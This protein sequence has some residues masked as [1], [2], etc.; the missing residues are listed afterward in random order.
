MP[1]NIDAVIES[2]N[3]SS[4]TDTRP[5]AYQEI[6]RWSEQQL[7][8]WQSDALRRIVKNHD[9]TDQDVQEILVMLKVENGLTV[10]G[11]VA[12]KRLSESDIPAYS[13]ASSKIVLEAM[14]ELKNVNAIVPGQTLKFNPSGLTIVYGHNAS[15]K[16]GYA[17]VLKKACRARGEKDEVLPDVFSVSSPGPAEAV[18]DVNDGSKSVPIK[19]QEGV[20]SPDSLAG[21]NVFDSKC[22]RVYVD[23]SNEVVYVP[24]GLDAFDK[25]AKL[26]EKLKAILQAESTAISVDPNQ[27]NDLHGSTSVGQLLATLSYQTNLEIVERLAKLQPDEE[28][29]LA[30]V[31][32]KLAELKVNDPK[33]KAETLRIKKRRI[34]RFLIQ[35]ERIGSTVSTDVIT[36][37]KTAQGELYTAKE[38]SK[39]ASQKSF[40]S[41]PLNGVTTD[42]WKIMY[43]AA[44]A[45]S[46]QHAYPGESFPVTKDGARCVL[47][48]QE[49]TPEAA[50]RLKQFEQFVTDRTE[51]VL[52]AAQQVFDKEV[53]TFKEITLTPYQSDPDL[54]KEIHELNSGVATQISS[55]LKDMAKIHTQIIES[56][57]SSKWESVYQIP[58][59]PCASIRKLVDDLEAKAKEFEKIST[60]EEIKKLETEYAELDV[61]RRLALKKTSLVDHIKKLQSKEKIRVCMSSFNTTGISRKNAELTEQLVTERLKEDLRTEFK[62]LNVDYIKIDLSKS[63]R[64]GVVFHKFQL[65][66]STHK[67]VN[68]SDVLSEGE[69]RAIAIGSLLAELQSSP[70]SGGIVFDDPVSSLDHVRREQV[71]KRLVVESKKRQVVIFT[72]DLFFLSSLQHYSDAEGASCSVQTLWGNRAYGTGN[73]DPNAPWDGQKVADRIK[74]LNTRLLEG[75]KRIHGDVSK[76]EDY[77]RRVDD[78]YNKLRQTWERAVEEK[79]FNDS[80]QRFR[81]S[82]Q[83]QRLKKVSFEDR[84]YKEVSDGVGKC[85]KYLHD[86]ASGVQGLTIPDP[87]GLESDLQALSSFTDRINKRNE[88]TEKKR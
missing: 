10:P 22:A 44:R 33:V 29:K 30:D 79:L 6:L 86:R 84:D 12:S 88:E 68:L 8:P 70:M 65:Q 66:S 1:E 83:L 15:G 14:R 67:A 28:K 82:V 69:Q 40:Q 2:R 63:G 59:E 80:V 56:A 73:C 31:E 32:K 42:P 7:L 71:A 57:T 37:I 78:F 9:L 87:S 36:K 54:E 39:L 26:Y 77:E 72:H 76:K 43:E 17:R 25:L 16:S 11:A 38:A 45:F 41:E 62:N 3:T 51:K 35:I 23:G 58:S 64:Q 46:Q 18:I 5:N 47:C 85:A 4:G 24:Y 19:W 21:I 60:A 75:I 13:S 49:L 55:W 20:A 61:R 34:E 53:K 27:F 50:N 81:E 52:K 74:Y 48:F